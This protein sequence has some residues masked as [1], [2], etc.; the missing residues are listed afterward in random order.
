MTTFGLRRRVA[1]Y[2]TRTVEEGEQLLVFEHATDDPGDPSGTQ[3]P[4]GAMLP[5][6]GIEAAALR[7]TEEETGLRELRFVRQLGG[8]ERAFHE[9]G[10]PSMTTFVHL[11]LLNDGPDAWEHTVTGADD[12]ERR[13]ADAGK[14]EGQPRVSGAGE[15][16]HPV[17][18]AT[19]DKGMVFVCR[20]EPLPLQVSLADDQAAF[21]DAVLA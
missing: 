7:E 1:C 5:F 6:E 8:Q 11:Q 18:G 21:I 16:D 2:V 13:V 9:P 12:R 14:D 15:G 17:S 19:G 4:A 3:V 20:W 10:G